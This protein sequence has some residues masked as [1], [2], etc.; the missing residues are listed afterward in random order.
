VFVRI[1][2]L[3]IVNAENITFHKHIEQNYKTGFFWGGAF[4]EVFTRQSFFNIFNEHFK[5]EGQ[6]SNLIIIKPKQ[7]GAGAMAALTEDLS[8]V[9]STWVGQLR[10]ARHSDSRD[11]MWFSAPVDTCTHKHIP[12]STNYIET[13][14]SQIK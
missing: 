3:I 7:S 2:L 13:K 9:P 4:Q 12:T 11:P 5:N 14:S 1:N 8:S 10:T 6:I